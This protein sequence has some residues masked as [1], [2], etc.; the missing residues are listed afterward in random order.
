MCIPFSISF[1]LS[2]SLSLSPPLSHNRVLE[3]NRTLDKGLT[4]EGAEI[5]ARRGTIKVEGGYKSSRDIRLK[6]VNEKQVAFNSD[7]MF[8][9]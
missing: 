8:F 6:E 7:F 1:S 4:E 9:L 2:L 3:G 5:L